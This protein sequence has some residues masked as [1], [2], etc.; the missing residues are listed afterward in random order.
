MRAAHG[1][2]P[3]P[4]AS[5]LVEHQVLQRFDEQGE[6]LEV[7]WG[8]EPKR[9]DAARISLFVRG[10]AKALGKRAV[11]ARVRKE[12]LLAYQARIRYYEQLRAG[13]SMGA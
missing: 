12:R 4:G 8:K 9:V 7:A 11:L 10:M 5:G 13:R 1:V 6:K 3:D 2:S